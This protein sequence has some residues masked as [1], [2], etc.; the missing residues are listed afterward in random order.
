MS[1]PDN[2]KILSYTSD[3][4][5]TEFPILWRFFDK[6]TVLAKVYRGGILEKELTY[7]QDYSVTPIGET[8]GKLVLTSPVAKGLV[9]AISRKEPY[10]QALELLNSG[11][12]DLVKLEE[13]LD[14]MVML[15]QQNRDDLGRG[16]QVPPGSDLTPEQFILD[17]LKKYEEVMAESTLIQTALGN[18]FCSSIEPFVTQ[19]GVAEYEVVSKIPLD[20]ILNNL[21]LVLGGVAQEPVTSFIIVDASHIRFTSDPGDGLRCWGVTSLSMSSPDIRLVVEAA[22]QKIV[23]EGDKQEGRAKVFADA[24]AQSAAAAASDAQEVASDK[25]H[26]DTVAGQI[27][28]LK[29][30]VNTLNPGEQATASYDPV[31][32]ILTFGVPKGDPGATAIATPTSLGSVIPQ[33]GNDDGLELETAGKLRVRKASA[34]QRGS[35]LASVTAAAGAVP[36][37][38]GN[39]VLDESWLKV[40]MDAVKDVWDVGDYKASCK[41][42]KPGWLLCNGAAVSRTTYKDLFAV[43]GTKFGVGDGTTTFNLPDFRSRT[44]WGAAGNLMEKIA[45]GLPNIEGNLQGAGIDE[46]YDSHSMF[47]VV[48]GAFYKGDASSDTETLSKGGLGSARAWYHKFDASRSNS[49]YGKSNTVQPPAIGVNIFIK[50]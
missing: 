37:A 2:Y 28:G 24:A 44:F 8:G 11:K 16:L 27:Q 50:Y 20:P 49:T 3:G 1:L 42:S 30:V 14:H 26:V 38:N 36:T 9:L 41:T 7:G 40:A 32:G 13:A 23:A 48:T 47:N 18:F 33:T 34:T 10:I 12:I 45:A 6:E 39:G 31:T 21:F 5:Q 35:V 4:S 19:S 22:I 43:I 25:Q 46:N 15:A 29:I 17:L